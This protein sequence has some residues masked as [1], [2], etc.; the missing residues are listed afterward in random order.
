MI[1]QEDDFS[2][3]HD[4]Y[5]HIKTTFSPNFTILIDGKVIPGQRHDIK[6]FF[7]IILC[8]FCSI[9]NSDRGCATVVAT[10]VYGILLGNFY[11][12]ASDDE[13][14]ELLLEQPAT[15]PTQI[16]KQANTNNK[17]VNLFKTISPSLYLDFSKV[18][19]FSCTWIFNPF[20]SA[21]FATADL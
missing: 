21:N 18:I 6:V 4:P 15:Q 12:S 17:E 14:P 1:L 16:N 8:L 19:V 13:P 20:D 2:G 9:V 3:I 5:L 10:S 7:V 11:G